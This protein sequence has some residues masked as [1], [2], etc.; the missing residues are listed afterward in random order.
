LKI[1]ELDTHITVGDQFLNVKSGYYYLSEYQGQTYLSLTT[2][3]KMTT[4][5]NWYGKFWANFVLDNFH[6]SVL[7]MIK[8]RNEKENLSNGFI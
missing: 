1:A 2:S 6:S 7:H 4:K 5:L 8:L 3:Y